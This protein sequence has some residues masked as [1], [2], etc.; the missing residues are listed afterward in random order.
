M[1]GIDSMTG[2][3]AADKYT[4]GGGYRMAENREQNRR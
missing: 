1:S 2:G 4:F 3:E